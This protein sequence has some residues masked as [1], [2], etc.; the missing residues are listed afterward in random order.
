MPVAGV[1][2]Q[3]FAEPGQSVRFGRRNSTSI[4]VG[5]RI[6]DEVVN[7][8]AEFAVA[9]RSSKGGRRSRALAGIAGSLTIGSTYPSLRQCSTTKRLASTAIG[10]SSHSPGGRWPNRPPKTPNPWPAKASPAS[11]SLVVRSG[12]RS[13]RGLAAD[14]RE[15]SQFQ[16]ECTAKTRAAGSPSSTRSGDRDEF[17]RR[18][19]SRVAGS[20]C[21]NAPGSVTVTTRAANST[22][23]ADGLIRIAWL[24]W[25]RHTQL[26]MCCSRL[27][28]RARWVMRTPTTANGRYSTSG[29]R[30]RD[31]AGITVAD[32][33][34]AT[35]VSRCSLCRKRA[36]C[37]WW[38]SLPTAGDSSGHWVELPMGAPAPITSS[39]RS[40]SSRTS[41]AQIQE[42]TFSVG[43]AAD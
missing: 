31:Y 18:K 35:H 4:E 33:R 9:E 23:A 5:L 43:L 28:T 40:C 7:A 39:V 30:E 42:S 2:Q 27:P 34:I 1:I 3:V 6:V 24:P 15:Q 20:L 19:L 12:S 11:W 25:V 17:L 36:P 32:R 22:C 16:A 10:S 37:R 38:P 21:G 29:A 13:C 8:E 41:R 26:C 14:A